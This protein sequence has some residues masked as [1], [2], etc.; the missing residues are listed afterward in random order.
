MLAIILA[1][2]IGFVAIPRANAIL[3]VGD[4]VSDPIT[5]VQ[6]TIRNI[7]EFT[8][9]ILLGG[10]TMAFIN[11]LNYFT[12]K[13][14]YDTAVWIAS[15][16]KGEG[17]LFHEQSFGDYL[18]DVALGAAGE[19]LGTL[20][21]VGFLGFNLCE[22]GGPDGPQLRLAL[23]LGI[24]QQY[25]PPTPRCEWG[26]IAE[27]W[28]TFV[29]SFESGEVLQRVSLSLSP[30]ETG[31]HALF[32]APLRIREEIR[33]T[34]ENAERDR[35][36]GGGFRSVVDLVTGR[37]RTPA[38]VVR[39]TALEEFSSRAANNEKATNASIIGPVLARG[40]TQVL[41]VGLSTF[42]NTLASQL[43]KRAI[44]DGLLVTGD[45]VA[46]CGLEALVTGECTDSPLSDAQRVGA[47]GRAAA[48][49]A[50]ADL[51]APR[52]QEVN[53]YDAI[54][55]FT[56]CPNRLRTPNN[57]VMDS[58]FAAAVRVAI[59]DQALT[60]REAVER[61]YLH[62]DW[63]IIGPSGEDQARNSD[64]YCYS[65]AYC[66]SNLVKLRKARIIPIG[67]ELAAL[68]ARGDDGRSATLTD[69]MVGF[70]HCP[71]P[72][73]PN[74][75][76]PKYRWC[77]LLDPN[78]LLKYPTSQCRLKVYGPTLVSEE[79]DI[80]AEVCV[81][82]PSCV[83]EGP[84]GTCEGGFGYCT[85]EKSAWRAQADTCPAHFASCDTF[86]SSAG[87]E[88]SVLTNT[89][90]K[91][92]CSAENAGCRAYATAQDPGNGTG[93]WVAETGRIFLDSE[94]G[95][96]EAKD[97]GC[98]EL[99]PKPV[100]MNLVRNASF[101]TDQDA[102]DG[103][104]DGRPDAWSGSLSL[105]AE[106]V[107]NADPAVG[108]HAVIP[109]TETPDAPWRAGLRQIIF[110]DPG[111]TY[112]VSFYGRRLADA[113][114][115]GRLTFELRDTT[116]APLALAETETSC[117]V[118]AGRGTMTVT[119]GDVR[120]GNGQ[121]VFDRRQCTFTAPNGSEH[122]E[123]V[124]ASDGQVLIDA[125]MLEEGS[126]ATT[127]RGEG[128][129]NPSA[130]Y[131]KLPPAWLGC[132]GEDS[133]PPECAS[134][135][136]MCRADEVGCDAYT[137]AAGGPSIPGTVSAENECPAVCAGYASYRQ[138]ANDFDF[139]EY[140]VH[141]IPSGAKVCSAAAAGCTEFTNLDAIATGGEG[142]EYW[143]SL[144]VCEKPA[145]S[146]LPTYYTWEGS[147]TTGFQLKEWH[148]KPGSPQAGETG[149]P[150]TVIDPLRDLPRCTAASYADPLN[151]NPDCREF[152]DDAGNVSHRLYSRTIVV[153]PECRALRATTLPVDESITDA[154][155]CAAAGGR[156]N[157]A[158]GQ[159]GFC[160]AFGG[161]WDS[162]TD[163]GNLGCTFFGY[164]PESRAC[165]AT[166][167]NCRLYTG[168]AGRNIRVLH[169]ADVE[170]GTTEGWGPEGVVTVS[171]ESTQVGGHSLRVPDGSTLERSVMGADGVRITQGGTYYLS[172]WAKG[173]GAITARFSN[174]PAG[175]SFTDA[176]ITVNAN[177]N[178]YEF[179]PVQVTWEP[180]ADERLVLSGFTDVSFVD[181]IILS[182]VASNIAL[183]K[184]SWVIPQV[185]DQN[186]AGATLPQAMLGCTA[187]RSR[188]SN[189]TVYLTGFAS[190]CREKAVGCTA[191]RQT[192]Q[193]VST[194]RESWNALCVIDAAATAPTSCQVDGRE[195]CTVGV[196]RRS[197]RWKTD[198]VPPQ[199]GFTL[200]AGGTCQVDGTVIV[201]PTTG[202]P[203]SVGA[204][205]TCTGQPSDLVVV[206]ADTSAFVVPSQRCQQEAA[207]CM[208]AG[209]ASGLQTCT[210]R[211]GAD[212]DSDPDVCTPA[213]GSRTCTCSVSGRI[214]AG[215]GG[216]GG[217]AISIPL[218]EVAAGESVCRGVLP[219]KE[220]YPA[221]T[222]VAYDDVTVLN[223]PARYN[224]SLC[225]LEANGCDAWASRR[226][227]NAPQYFKHADGRVCAYRENVD[228]RGAAVS[229]WFLE[230]TDLPCDRDYLVAGVRYGL[231]SNGDPD[232]KGFVGS[233]PRQYAGCT[234]FDDPAKKTT[235]QPRG[236]P[237]YFIKNNKLDDTSCKGQVSL[238]NGCVL[239]NDT[240]DPVLS[241]NAAGTYALDPE[242]RSLARSPVSGVCA[243]DREVCAERT[244]AFGV[245]RE[246][247]TQRTQGGG[248]NSNV[249]CNAAIGETCDLNA[250]DANVVLKVRRD[251]VCA[252]WLACKSSS[253]VWDPSLKRFR[254]VCDAVGLCNESVSTAEGTQC[255]SWV[256]RPAQILSKDVYQDRT[257]GYNGTDYSGYAIPHM[258]PVESLSQIFVG[259]YCTHNPGRSCTNDSDCTSDPEIF[260]LLHGT[261]E[262]AVSA[263]RCGDPQY[264]LARV[265]DRCAVANGATCSSGSHPEW[266]SGS[267]WFGQCAQSPYGQT[268][269]GAVIADT[270]QP[271]RPI[272][273]N[274]NS[275]TLACRAYPERNSPFPNSVVT[276]W[277]LEEPSLSQRSVA[278]SVQ[279]SFGQ[280]SLC[281]RG[282][283]CE[284]AYN[285]ADYRS[286][287]AQLYLAPEAE[288]PSGVC[289]GGT[290]DQQ[291]CDPTIP[292]RD[293][294][295]GEGGSCQALAKV[296]SFQGLSGYCLER[297]LATPINGLERD[298][299][300][301]QSR[302]CATWYPVD[303]PAGTPDIYNSYTSAGYNVG[304][305]YFCAMPEAYQRVVP[306]GATNRKK[307]TVRVDNKPYEIS[308]GEAVAVDFTDIGGGA[309][310]SADLIADGYVDSLGRTPPA[311]G[312]F[313][314][315]VPST[316]RVG[317]GAIR[318]D[319]PANV[320][321]AIVAP[322]DT[323][324]LF[325]SLSYVCIPRNSRH[326]ADPEKRACEPPP[327]G[328][329]YFERP[330]DADA[331]FW[332]A[333][334]SGA[335]AG[336][337]IYMLQGSSS[338]AYNIGL[339][340][341]D[342]KDAKFIGGRSSDP[343]K[344]EESVLTH[345]ADC[346]ASDTPVPGPGTVSDADFTPYFGCELVAQVATG[347]RF[348][349]NKAYTGRIGNGRVQPPGRYALN[350][351]RV[352]SLRYL[353]ASAPSPYGSILS[354]D[355]ER[356]SIKNNDFQPVELPTC[357]V[358]NVWSLPTVDD[359]GA[360]VCNQGQLVED[361]NTEGRPYMNITVSRDT[362]TASCTPGIE[363][364]M[365]CSGY[366]GGTSSGYDGR[367][368]DPNS[369]TK[370]AG[371]NCY[372]VCVP[373]TDGDRECSEAGFGSCTGQTGGVTHCSRPETDD[374]FQQPSACEDPAS[375]TRRV[376]AGRCSGRASGRSCAVATDCITLSCIPLDHG[377]GVCEA[378][379]VPPESEGSD[380]DGRSRCR[381]YAP[382]SSPDMDDGGRGS[383]ELLQQLF[384]KTL[385]TFLYIPADLI[386]GRPG[387][388]VPTSSSE[389]LA[390]ATDLVDSSNPD[391]GPIIYDESDSV[392]QPPVVVTVGECDKDGKCLEG[393]GNTLKV[394]GQTNGEISGENFRRVTLNF[395]G[396]AQNDQMPIRSVL[397]DWGDGTRTGDNPGSSFKNRRGY[398]LDLA[399]GEYVSRCSGGT[400]GTSPEACDDTNPFTFTHVYTCDRAV[401]EECTASR[402]SNCV[403]R[404]SAGRQ[405][406][407]F[408]PHV[409]IK[410]NWGFC[411][412]SCPGGAA[413]ASCYDSTTN[414]DHVEDG[415]P[416]ECDISAA[417]SDTFG[418]SP[419]SPYTEF[420][421]RVLIYP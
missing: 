208:L 308:I 254:D 282:Q 333:Q 248:C 2:A 32:Q 17:P 232:Y 138:E 90:D 57:C 299:Y 336:A 358:N 97:I 368:D 382:L 127:F 319:C 321:F 172:F 301:Q 186:T 7:D 124:L 403:G 130:E 167:N 287:Q 286:G 269:L 105:W 404:D 209:K 402:T 360:L 164:A 60:I 309:P 223:N 129:D 119:P 161:K 92:I 343:S 62:G 180:G 111:Q 40:V 356:F 19:A 170:A 181:Q 38:A 100:R 302:A 291:A 141:L 189:Q 285:K 23:A 74:P 185:C 318:V 290:R 145:G 400:F 222:T 373:G 73:D 250:Q 109:G 224:A 140:P 375:G 5:N 231:W 117:T 328:R 271:L 261:D 267:C 388:Y 39:E 257:F 411:N 347:G 334:T 61:G 274:Q 114:G 193:S 9:K 349:E 18:G 378:S 313:R 148:L 237:Y 253:P 159:C 354:N 52:I 362:S 275:E 197:C 225:T 305:A 116:G 221:G 229:G 262:P 192:Q 256:N 307:W 289:Q 122:L 316:G 393:E 350:D 45:E 376:F 245:I 24:A 194:G 118:S 392:G 398:V 406:C 67:F 162:A 123:L 196:N 183:V 150:P 410:D 381:S 405:M 242:G 210:L 324:G 75:N 413:G 134:Y 174:A 27:S 182:E 283:N 273:T 320:G 135:S 412:G 15:G 11:S 335:G 195:V 363:G 143:S 64:P 278:Q 317:Q 227:N 4:V 389:G 244:T 346:Q 359:G 276:T 41:S 94:A 364:N 178:R 297:D 396:H 200:A 131:L 14:A 68:E 152:F 249:D 280:A 160:D 132:T 212:A 69:L 371:S 31:I 33:R 89:V 314:M 99:L 166:E 344:Y 149:A 390:V 91:S 3:G 233:C 106:D 44:G 179:G 325:S 213:A 53:N 108:G 55:E 268:G 88:V 72:D 383:I 58:G 77:H 327:T 251:R 20:S 142:R 345:Y 113:E 21:E 217:A 87:K 102:A 63:P 326:M 329:G 315:Y 22:P 49:V 241:Y 139:A 188:Q 146:V 401:L 199:V 310:S 296:N 95:K 203:R 120:D 353:W 260:R 293:L 418:L 265:L 372:Q 339:V 295:C 47:G 42:V 54:T 66:Y 332:R 369:C 366:D 294:P 370:S 70:T 207:G 82:A 153:T 384:A 380:C 420:S 397:V 184:D 357:K 226:E 236:E 107:A 323:D 156:F 342:G 239:F 30:G 165:K 26:R 59:Q 158:A 399:S 110:V 157:A 65:G 252:E 303:R 201:D 1:G 175:S 284:C 83:K 177:W 147:D 414:P 379:G 331:A 361:V 128:Y 43:L 37:Q 25:E 36:E 311:G 133:D 218:C 409:Q 144:R 341:D 126:T 84:N 51:L 259:R 80:R 386:L 79:T 86:R 46:R 50:F 255:T 407:I 419:R 12:Q 35:E 300:N 355:I 330:S 348:G 198:D 81:D 306:F 387:R 421:G 351:P 277:S 206:P 288:A 292:Q 104:G 28:D 103:Q 34:T 234:E 96:C 155:V 29:G 281:E 322:R 8:D 395:F 408:K 377:S 264:R 415:L 115:T 266:G 76:D 338:L 304:N 216:A 168:N 263:T 190:L 202:R 137:P 136:G 385:R 121:L 340:R 240:S 391:E 243:V 220:P 247:R 191:Y 173:R 230:G 272:G 16:G 312:E 13:I 169:Q 374:E 93:D 163:E 416:N 238:A 171:T 10:V 176:G 298:T 154:A 394:N 337:E 352:A 219:W 48:Q 270:A 125:V 417:A 365:K 204:G 211:D 235:E 101:E 187:Y 258:Y 215:L 151:P 279:Q 112:T 246:C 98:T 56:V 78:W 85:Q 71:T 214:G 6:T 367:F 205:G 228:V